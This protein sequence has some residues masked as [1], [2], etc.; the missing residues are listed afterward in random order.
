[1]EWAKQKGADAR[2]GRL[3]KR[4][5]IG[6]EAYPIDALLGFLDGCAIVADV[7]SGRWVRCEM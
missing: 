4:G 1:M 6:W 7:E 5:G 3:S 2:G